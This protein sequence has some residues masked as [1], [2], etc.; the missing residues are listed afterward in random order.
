MIN[1]RGPTDLHIPTS[2]QP[3]ET[4]EIGSE[5]SSTAACLNGLPTPKVLPTCSL[6]PGV[7]LWMNYITL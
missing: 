2:K 1:S 5:P 7:L 3:E 4:Q 6:V